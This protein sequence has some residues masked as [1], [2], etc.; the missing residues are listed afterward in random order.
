MPPYLP[1][2]FLSYCVSLSGSRW[3][4]HKLIIPVH[5]IHLHVLD[6]SQGSRMVEALQLRALVS[7]D[8]TRMPVSDN[9]SAAFSTG[10]ALAIIVIF[11]ALQYPKE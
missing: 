2:N 3:Q 8:W 5:R 10:Y 1:I 11:F 6:P 4:K 9:R 7:N